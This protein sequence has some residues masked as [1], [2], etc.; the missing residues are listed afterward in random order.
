MVVRL[1]VGFSY[2]RSMFVKEHGE[3]DVEAKQK[4]PNED[5]VFQMRSEVETFCMK[6]LMFMKL[7]WQK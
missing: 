2:N 3:S 7:K 5:G 1:R 4:L 6:A